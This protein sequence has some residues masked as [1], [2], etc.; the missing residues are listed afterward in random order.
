MI[1]PLL[2]RMTSYQTTP[3]RVTPSWNVFRR[4]TAILSLPQVELV[5]SASGRLVPPIFETKGVLY[6]TH[7]DIWIHGETEK[8][9]DIVGIEP[10]TSRKITKC[11][12]RALPTELKAHGRWEAYI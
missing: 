6:R 1:S 9:V 3:L 5:Y 8:K 7:W 11:E 4:R 2:N 10:T 12:A